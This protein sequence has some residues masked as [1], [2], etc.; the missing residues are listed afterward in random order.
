MA[1]SGISNDTTVVIYGDNNN[2]FAAWALWQMKIYGHSDVRLMNGG[3]R[4][5]LGEGRALT[6]DMAQNAR[7]RYTIP[8]QPDFPIQAP[9][10]QTHAAPPQTSAPPADA[11]T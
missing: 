3:G 4:K 10:C 6:T 11:R 2:W 5:W 9:L 7:N 8:G 1:S